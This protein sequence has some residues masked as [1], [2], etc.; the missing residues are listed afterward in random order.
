MNAITSRRGVQTNQVEAPIARA[1]EASR[2][3]ATPGRDTRVPSRAQSGFR[4]RSAAK[5]RISIR[6]PARR[7][8]Q[9]Q[10]RN[11][12]PPT[13][14]ERR[15]AKRASSA[16]RCGRMGGAGRMGNFDS[17]GP[18]GANSSG[19]LPSTGG[20]IAQLD[21]TDSSRD[22]SDC[23]GAGEEGVHPHR[24]GAGL[25]VPLWQDRCAQRAARPRL[26]LRRGRA[27]SRQ[28]GAVAE[29]P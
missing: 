14:K 5:V 26:T 23:K 8:S 1:A 17:F 4:H 11:S 2:A 6:G 3:T 27:S 7:M 16:N 13:R 19:S 9:N 28:P 24:S 15:S 22:G 25:L 20:S 10:A 29:S 18:V 12:L 21:F